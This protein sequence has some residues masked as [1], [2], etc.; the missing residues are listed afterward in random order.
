MRKRAQRFE[1]LA[2]SVFKHSQEGIV[3]TDMYNHIIDANPASLRLS[4]YSREE[5]LGKDPRMFSSGNHPRS[6]YTTMWKA[7]NE[8]GH[9]QGEIQ[10]RKKSGEFYTEQLSIDVVSDRDGNL[11]HYVA[12]FSDISYLKEHA[13]ALKEIA[14]N[15]ALTGLPNRLLL[16]DRMQ[17]ALS[18]AKRQGKQIAVCYLDLDGFKP[19]ND[20][21]GHQAGDQILIEVARR[22]QQ[23]LRTGDTVARLGGD[24]FVLLMLDIRSTSE[25]EQLL[26]RVL[27]TI[28][29]PYALQDTT[30]TLFASIGIATHPPDSEEAD[31]LL[32]HADQ[33]MYAAKQSGKNRYAFFDPSEEQKAVTINSIQREIQIALAREQLRLYYQPK[34]NMA[35]G[36]MAGVEA[37]IRWQHPEK[38]L[39]TPDAFLPAIEHSELI[40]DL[41]HWVLRQALTQM[42]AWKMEGIELEVSV[43]IAALQLQRV[44]FVP[45]LKALLAEFPDVPASRLQ[46]EILETAALQDINAVSKIIA[47]CAELGV[48]FALD[49]FGTGY[50]SLTYLRR[51]PTQVLKIDQSFIRDLLSD[52]EDLAITKGILGLTQAFQR[53]VVAEGVETIEHGTL[54]LKLGCELAQGYGIARP[55]PAGDLPAWMDSYQIPS[56]WKKANLDYSI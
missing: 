45:S 35:S 26:A 3:V 25:L 7:I 13:M 34:V 24:E 11:Q 48:Q 12:A 17:Q 5:V 43:N 19:V 41:G 10:N 56:E 8:F 2:A 39:L 23:N 14:Y 38:G 20:N 32:R 9:W 54:L 50:S 44:D 21:H 15:D 1:R 52:P 49:D 47:Q 53:T 30:L 27:K 22:L 36:A 29:E 31:T 4:G 28:A 55:M 51:L 18:H 46:L 16:Q 42:R 33:A 6:F 37:L 40:F